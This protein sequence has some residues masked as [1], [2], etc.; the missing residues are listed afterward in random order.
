MSTAVGIDIFTGISISNEDV[1]AFKEIMRSKTYYEKNK[2]KLKA[3]MHTYYE[4][5][6]DQRMQYQRTYNK[7]NKTLVAQKKKTRY[8]AN[9][10]KISQHRKAMNKN[11]PHIQRNQ[12]LSRLYNL[13]IE[14][15][16]ILYEQQNGL[17][18]ICY[19][20]TSKK[21]M[22]TDHCHTTEVVRSLLCRDCNL[23]LANFKDDVEALLK[24]VEY[25]RL[26]QTKE[27]VG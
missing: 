7:V 11:N 16:D 17:C 27:S 23:G 3:T 20:P 9:K 1:K 18:A 19:K 8:E 22:H 25:I 2:E 5:H 15:W 4:N 14:Q 6:K 24:A 26:Y 12:N 13:T 21:E 10:E